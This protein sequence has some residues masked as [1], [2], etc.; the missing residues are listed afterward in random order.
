MLI[1]T[2]RSW[3]TRRSKASYAGSAPTAGPNA[4]AT[5]RKWII[6]ESRN[7]TPHLPTK[8]LDYLDHDAQVAGDAFDNNSFLNL[9]IAEIAENDVDLAV[10]VRPDPGHA[11]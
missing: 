6:V 4:Y 10:K 2:R 3:E 1:P 8:G 7:A 11:A 5:R 9:V